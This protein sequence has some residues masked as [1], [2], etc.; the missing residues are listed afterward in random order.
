MQISLSFSSYS[1]SYSSATTIAAPGATNAADAARPLPGGVG[2]CLYCEEEVAGGVYASDPAWRCSCCAALT[3]VRCFCAN[4][5]RLTTVTAKFESKIKAANQQLRM[6]NAC[7]RGGVVGSGNG[8]GGTTAVVPYMD[9]PTAVL[10]PLHAA[11]RGLSPTSSISGVDRFDVELLNSPLPVVGG[12]EGEVVGVGNNDS[13]DDN[14]DLWTLSRDE[15]EKLDTCFLVPG[16]GSNAAIVQRLIL[17]SSCVRHAKDDGGGSGDNGTNVTDGKIKTK[18]E[19]EKEEEALREEDDAPTEDKL[20]RVDKGV[21]K[22]QQQSSQDTTN[23]TTTSVQTKKE[24]L[25]GVKRKT[26]TTATSTNASKQRRKQSWWRRALAPRQLQWT[27]WSFSLHGLPFACRPILVFVNVK[28]GPQMGEALHRRFLR[29]LHPLQVVCLPRDSPEPALRLFAFCPGMRILC[30][31]GDGTAG[32]ILSCLDALVAERNS[33]GNKGNNSLGAATQTQRQR[34]LTSVDG[35]DNKEEG[36]QRVDSM[37]TSNNNH[38][39]NNEEE[40]RLWTPPP[41]AVFPLGTGNDL[42]R[43]LGWG[44]GYGSWK[45][46]GV[47]GILQA[48]A[49]ASVALLDRWTLTFIEEVVAKGEEAGEE[50]KEDGALPPS[51]SMDERKQKTTTSIIRELLSPRLM[52]ASS[53]PSTPPSPFSLPLGGDDN[54][55][56]EATAATAPAGTTAPPHT[57]PTLKTRQKAMSNYLG[58]GVDAKV[59]L[60]FHDMRETYP[61]WFQSQFGNK[62]VYTGV[63]ALDI[64]SGG[65][66]NLPDKISIECDGDPVPLPVGAEGILIVNI[67]SYMG[68]VDLWGSGGGPGAVAGHQSLCD[69]VLEIVAVGGSWHLGQLTVG[70]SRAVRLAQGRRIVVNTREAVPMQV[71]GE[72][73]VQPAGRVVVEFCGQVRM[74]RRLENKPVAAVLRQLE[75]ALEGAVEGGVI[76]RGQHDVLSRELAAKLQTAHL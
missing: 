56:G 11:P 48:V 15:V 74:L 25:V 72:P 43:C 61:Q 71:D 68:G 19:K 23:T 57:N 60:E 62:L 52:N 35:E 3:H 5:P 64:V 49:Q 22:Q 24:A 31:G 58:I 6:N 27:D 65:Q 20:T 76:T 70:L 14:D 40:E 55:N 37:N 66:L 30:V 32:W 18:K 53:T 63:G 28:S 17:P 41:V 12:G 26:S 69:G 21:E 59:A 13:D 8:N 16:G 9:S 1:S 67:P 50:K 29:V 36:G 73:F 38:Y 45:T 42:A 10:T 39:T 47:V 54:G 34:Q 4:H 51:S 33:N 46:E 44:G 2:P 75:D 7:K